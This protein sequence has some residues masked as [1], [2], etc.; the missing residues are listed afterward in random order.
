VVRVSAHD[1]KESDMNATSLALSV[2]PEAGAIVGVDLAKNVFQLCVAGAAWRP[3]ESQRLTRSQFETP[4]VEMSQR[5]EAVQFRTWAV[6]RH[7]VAPSHF[8]G[9]TS[10]RWVTIEPQRCASPSCFEVRF[11]SRTAVLASGLV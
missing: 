3:R 4:S 11:C 1:A 7:I 9:K 6:Q 5:G 2:Q 8:C 10:L